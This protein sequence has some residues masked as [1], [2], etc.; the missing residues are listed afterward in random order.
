MEPTIQDL[1]K[2]R[3][4]AAASRRLRLALLR[5]RKRLED[6]PTDSSRRGCSMKFRA[7]RS[8]HTGNWHILDTEDSDRHIATFVCTMAHPDPEDLARE[9]AIFKNNQKGSLPSTK[10]SP[11]QESCNETNDERA[12]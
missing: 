2:V 1:E 11:R 3:V 4:A 12:I 8:K 7:E 9:Y 6:T 10:P 5:S